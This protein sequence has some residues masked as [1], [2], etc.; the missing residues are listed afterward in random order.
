MCREP[1]GN[2]QQQFLSDI[3]PKLDDSAWDAYWGWDCAGPQG[4]CERVYQHFNIPSGKWSGLKHL[5]TASSK[6]FANASQTELI[7]QNRAKL[8]Q[9]LNKLPEPAVVTASEVAAA[10]EQVA[11]T[12][13]TADQFASQAGADDEKDEDLVRDLNRIRLHKQSPL[14]QTEPAAS[15]YT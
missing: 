1:Q 4:L 12:Q 7:K 15:E 14:T 3:N 13:P 2:A 5:P 11:E 9:A 8:D 10:A 6:D